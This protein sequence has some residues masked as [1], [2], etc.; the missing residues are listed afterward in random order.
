MRNIKV[1]VLLGNKGFQGWT[2]SLNFGVLN[3]EPVNQ[4]HILKVAY[5]EL[6][7]SD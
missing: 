5:T 2:I 4:I 6:C 7:S 1:A 3:K